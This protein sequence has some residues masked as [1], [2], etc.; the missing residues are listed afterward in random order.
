M[1]AAQLL[2]RK[3]EK[4][5]HFHEKYMDIKSCEIHLHVANHSLQRRPGIIVEIKKKNYRK[6]SHINEK[7]RKKI[8]KI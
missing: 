1:A 8:M 5:T 7:I 6:E 4:R 2:K 3:R